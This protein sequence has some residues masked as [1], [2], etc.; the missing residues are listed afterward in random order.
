MPSKKQ[1]L[2]NVPHRRNIFFTGRTQVLDD[3]RQALTARGKAA[4]SGIGGLGKTQTAVEYAYRHRGEYEAVLWVK[5]DSEDS[6]RADL[7]TIAVKL[8]LPEKDETDR[9][10]V[11]TAVTRWLDVQGN[12]LLILDNADDLG[13]ISDLLSR[14]WSGHILLTTRA[15]ATGDISRVEIKIMHPEEGSLFL[16]RRAKV[17]EVDDDLGAATGYDQELAAEITQEMGGLPLALDQAGAFIEEES[18]SL[19]EY[20]KLYRKEGDKLR[21]ERG[22]V[23]NADHEPVSITFS[24]AFQQVGSTNAAAADM[25]RACAFLAPDAIPEEIFV[26]GAGELGENLAPMADGGISLVKMIGDAARFSLILRNAKNGTVEI[27]RV[28]Q[29]VLKDEMSADLQQLWAERVV[30]ALSE[31][32]PEVEHQN[33]PLCEKILPHAQEAA[34]MMG[35]YSFEF[36]EAARLL[37]RAGQYCY[38]RGEYSEAEPL[39]MQS[40]NMRESMFDPDHLDVSLSLNNLALLY[41]EQGKYDEAEP[42]YL[43]ALSSREKVLGP[44]H[45]YV[46]TS[47]NNLALLYHSQGKYDEAEPL[48][49]RALRICEKV[50]GPE[51]S[52]VAMCLNNI[53]GLYDNQGRYDEAEPLYLRALRICEKVLGP[54]HPVMATS[55]NNLA[56][57]YDDQGKYAE[58]EPLHIRAL[59]IREK[60][61]G[62]EH[63]HVATSLNNLALLYERQGKCAKAQPLY[64]R[65]LSI[66][67][68]S[69]GLHHPR[70]LVIHNNY[71]D[72]LQKLRKE[73]EE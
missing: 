54:E 69:L 64:E 16:L 20:L 11:V 60:E 10:L 35:E 71:I 70:T 63:P 57:L 43:R 39:L 18:S 8:N 66:Y 36:K 49:L 2:W 53:A 14:E 32:F 23:I 65:A 59:T 12:W 22:G 58:A 44:E 4:L 68:K 62:P 6:L 27:H 72:L 9:A 37:N 40:L 34:K 31:S 21:A 47:L 24:L 3:L 50:L 46:A 67:E 13:L 41:K 73:T 15:H 26:S 19:A 29:Q 25:L 38:Q 48:Y 17:I 1:A 7:A 33:W 55:L 28:V 56:S 45:R 30:R 52:H 42:L 51:H 61:L 5:A